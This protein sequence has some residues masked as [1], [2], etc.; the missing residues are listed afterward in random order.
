MDEIRPDMRKRRLR[1]LIFAL[2]LALLLPN[3]ALAA[4]TPVFSD[5]AGH[6]ARDV[7]ERGARDGL[8][9]GYPDG[10]FRP[11]DPITAAQMITI[12]CRI[13]NAQTMASPAATGL[14]GSEWYYEAAAR[15]V[16]LGIVPSGAG[17]DQP[18]TRRGAAVLTAR[19][20]QYTAAEPDCSMLG[21]FSDGA[22]LKGEERTAMALL[23][24]AGVFIGYDG[25]L[26]VDSFI[27][28]AEFLTI[29][30]RIVPHILLF[31]CAASDIALTD[32]AAPFAVIRAQRPMTLTIGGS[33]HIGRLVYAGSTGAAVTIAASGA[34]RIDTL[35]VGQAGD[36]V[37]VGQ[38]VGRVEVTGDGQKVTVDGAPAEIVI[39]GKNDTVTGAAAGA[40]RQAEDS[41]ITGVTV[42]LSAPAVLPAGQ[43]L[44]VTANI[45]SPVAGKVCEAI[46]SVDGVKVSDIT[47]NLRAG[48]QGLMLTYNYQYSRDMALSSAVGL[49]LRYQTVDGA[50]Q[51]VSATAELTLQ[52]YGDDYYNQYD[53]DR[54]LKLVTT[55]Y[56]GDWTLGWALSHD[57]Q[58][59]E[60]EIWINAKGYS[61]KTQYLCWVS[62]AMQRVNVFAGYAGHWALIQSFLCGTGATQSQ[63]PV[64]V[65]TIFGRSAAGWTTSTYCVRP[66]VNFKVGSGY[67][68]HSRLY[69]PKHNY[70]IDSSIG[71]PISHGCVRMYDADVRWIYD[72]IP[73]DT[74][75]VVY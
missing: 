2:G 53:T 42:S 5:I 56:Q 50:D 12:F 19:A 38:G 18:I 11:D 67:A 7:I 61:S 13:L 10:T 32:V 60:K 20:F 30:Y 41:G 72:N 51:M 43:A 69:D 59:F 48:E 44:Q 64:G 16:A 26:A 58:S 49:E 54:V 27:T 46:W 68:F 75:V 65:Y 6:W 25:K 31:N 62:T 24:Q 63:T 14:S 45:T 37:I 23:V 9:L 15:A 35:V 22:S 55:G 70:L 73:N 52:N 1:P 74:T 4:D 39:S 29:Y 36:P 66:V 28:R 17:L 8:V 47:L 40:V 21:A 71:Y 3:A 33:A 34:A 57:Y